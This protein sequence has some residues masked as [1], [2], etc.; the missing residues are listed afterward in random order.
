MGVCM[1]RFIGLYV[2]KVSLGIVCVVVE[3]VWYEV[4]D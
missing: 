4:V 1:F 3:N 2:Y